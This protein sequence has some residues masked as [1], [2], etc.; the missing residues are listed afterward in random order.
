M[1]TSPPTMQEVIDDS[2]TYIPLQEQGTS[3]FCERTGIEGTLTD[4]N[5]A[6]RYV[7]GPTS[8]LSNAI[9]F[10]SS[11][12][13]R[14]AFASVPSGLGGMTKYT[15]SAW[16]KAQVSA[17]TN[18]CVVSFEGTASSRSYRMDTHVSAST[19]KGP[20][21]YHGGSQKVARNVLNNA[22][23][24]SH[25]AVTVD[26][27][28]GTRQSY[29]DGQLDTELTGSPLAAVYQTLTYY[30]IGATTHSSPQYYHDAA[31]AGVGIWDKVLSQV[32][33]NS[34]YE[35]QGYNPPVTPDV[36]YNPFKSHAFYNRF[37]G[38]DRNN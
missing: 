25:V 33:I 6:G 23:Q 13:R 11:N 28:T 5:S 30:A 22:D 29:V 18:R 24:W 34:L 1:P 14:I 20:V 7:S 4:T 2:V 8:S 19:L 16:V 12:L 36:F 27:T 9:K 35:E 10:D 17:T 21:F 26:T 31:I 37:F 15:V 32:E 3:F 38:N